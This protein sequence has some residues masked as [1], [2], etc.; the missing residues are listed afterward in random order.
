MPPADSQRANVS[1]SHV[2]LPL[3]SHVQF[4]P[5]KTDAQSLRASHAAWVV[6]VVQS[7]VGH[8]AS[9]MQ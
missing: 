6:S 5:V 7:G 4:T 3:S 8:A 9:G 1:D 2:Q